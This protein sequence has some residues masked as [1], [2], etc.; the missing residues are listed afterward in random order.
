MPAKAVNDPTSW[1]PAPIRETQK[2]LLASDRPSSNAAAVGAGSRRR[3]SA[4]QTNQ[5]PLHFH[6]PEIISYL[7]LFLKFY[8]TLYL[9]IFASLPQK[10][11][12]GLQ[13]QFHEHLE[14]HSPTTVSEKLLDSHSDKAH[15][16]SLGTRR[17]HNAIHISHTMTNLLFR[18]FHCI[19]N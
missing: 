3:N 4:F 13:S 8:N 9:I 12:A 18:A 14:W 6:K 7:F 15:G 11:K 10:G 5:K 16:T 1:A 2:Q 17:V 19:F